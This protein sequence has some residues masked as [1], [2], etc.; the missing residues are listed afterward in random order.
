MV[1]AEQIE[2][3]LGDLYLEF[4]PRVREIK[5]K[6]FAMFARKIYAGKC[7]NPNLEK[8][9]LKGSGGLSIKQ[10]SA[11]EQVDECL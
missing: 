3:I 4:R 10:G 9:G 1:S 11:L 2:R 5:K 6:D 7:L 8:K